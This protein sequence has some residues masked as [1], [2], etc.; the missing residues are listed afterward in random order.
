MYWN[1]K[2]WY[3][4]MPLNIPYPYVLAYNILLHYLLYKKGLYISVSQAKTSLSVRW[5]VDYG[6]KMLEIVF[7]QF[8]CVP[9]EIKQEKSALLIT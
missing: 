8:E 3:Q 5:F 6:V 1:P 7:H 2:C 9:I 4:H